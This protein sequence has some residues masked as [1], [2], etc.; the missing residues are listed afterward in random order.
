MKSREHHDPVES[1]EILADQI[2]PTRDMLNFRSSQEI[3]MVNCLIGASY[4]KRDDFKRSRTPT[5][6]IPDPERLKLNVSVRRLV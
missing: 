3:A 2:Q 6:V 5:P 4:S 1:L